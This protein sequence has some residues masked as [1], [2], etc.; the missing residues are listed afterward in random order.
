MI[1][2]TWRWP[3]VLL[4][5]V[6]GTAILAACG[7]N[8]DGPAT[9]APSGT[10][11]PSVTGELLVLG[12]S[13]LTDAFEEIGKQFEAEHQGV[14]VKFSFA[15]SSALATQIEEGGVGD[16]FASADRAQMDRLQRD[17]HVGPADVFARNEPVIV[18]PKGSTAVTTFED[19]AKDGVRLVLAGPDVPIGNYS[20]Q[21][22]AKASAEGGIDPRFAQRVLNNVRSEEANVRAVLAKVQLGEADAGIVYAT[23]VAAAGGDVERIDIPGQYNVVAE[24]P[25][26][27]SVHAVNKPLAAV[28]IEFLLSAKGQEVMEAY[29]FKGK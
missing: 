8:D 6:L 4:L 2:T 11:T 1:R 13:S 14:T 18:V 9:T 28:F 21:V 15:A 17:I 26:A 25:V 20:R 10:A 22:L 27:I 24:Y 29:G 12:A 16:V 19:L 7:G 23:D 3:A 5:A